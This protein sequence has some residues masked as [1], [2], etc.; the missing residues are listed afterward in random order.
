MDIYRCLSRDFSSEKIK[1]HTS[2]KWFWSA[3]KAQQVAFTHCAQ[4]LPNRHELLYNLKPAAFQRLFVLCHTHAECHRLTAEESLQIAEVQFPGQH[5]LQSTAFTRRQEKDLP[6]S[7]YSH[8]IT[9]KLQLLPRCAIL[10]IKK[11]KTLMT[12]A[13]SSMGLVTNTGNNQRA[14]CASFTF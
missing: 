6:R 4:H 13:F 8:I 7:P 12:T 11:N 1:M 14:S 10:Y 2:K 5:H 3:Y 9:H